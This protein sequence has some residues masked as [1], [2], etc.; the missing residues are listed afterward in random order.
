MPTIARRRQLDSGGD[1]P[2][3]GAMS[4]KP[5]QRADSSPTWWAA[6]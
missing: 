1:R 2:H 5:M 3:G 6:R 4:H